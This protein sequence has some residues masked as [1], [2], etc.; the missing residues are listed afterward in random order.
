MI[1][2]TG[3]GLCKLECIIKKYEKIF[4][5]LHHKRRG[6]LRNQERGFTVTELLVVVGIIGILAAVAVPSFLAYAPNYRLKAAARDLYS[7]MQRARLHAIKEN[8]PVS[9]RFTTVALPATGG[10]YTMFVDDGAGGG[11][12]SNGVLDGTE[13]LLNTVTMT[14]QNSLVFA[15]FGGFGPRVTYTPKGVI[16]GSQM[17]SVTISNSQR[18][19]RI[20]VSAG[21][22]F[23][24]DSI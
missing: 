24:L 18:S 20:T 12:A 19:Y 22:G 9:F 1:T 6:K 17:G 4:T 21:G 5:M 13:R 11:V 8:T 3:Y 2:A 15:V 7:D 14:G 23:R 16:A 10:G